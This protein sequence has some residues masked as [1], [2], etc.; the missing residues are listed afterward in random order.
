MTQKRH[1]VAHAYVF[2]NGLL[3]NRVN[4]IS[5]IIS[6]IKKKIKIKNPLRVTVIL[7]DVGKVP[8]VGKEVIVVEE[9]AGEI[10][11]VGVVVVVVDRRLDGRYESSELIA[12]LR[13]WW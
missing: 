11:K 8:K 5:G 2:F 1:R 10:G 4:T 13:W 3:R 6:N 9:R 7:I 12:N